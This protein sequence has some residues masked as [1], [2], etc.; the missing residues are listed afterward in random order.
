MRSLILLAGGLSAGSRAARVGR[1]VLDRPFSSSL[2]LEGP[3]LAIV[4]CSDARDTSGRYPPV[5][6]PSHDWTLCTLESKDVPTRDA[7]VPMPP[8]RFTRASIYESSESLVNDLLVLPDGPME[9]DRVGIR[10]TAQTPRMRMFGT[11]QIQVANGPPMPEARQSDVLQTVIAECLP[12]VD[13][14]RG[15]DAR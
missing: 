10:K 13:A 7:T 3:S 4:H 8:Y 11:V 15:G 6:Y 5:C 12:I 1:P 2:R 14:I 9:S